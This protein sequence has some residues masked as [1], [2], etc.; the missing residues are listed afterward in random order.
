MMMF[1]C[2]FV[3][4]PGSCVVLDCIDYGSLLSFLL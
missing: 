1:S 4:F 2:V 3:T